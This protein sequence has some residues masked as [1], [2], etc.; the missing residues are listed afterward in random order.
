MPATTRRLNTDSDPGG[1]CVIVKK[2]LVSRGLLRI[3]PERIP[4]HLGSRRVTPRVV[5]VGEREVKKRS[6][7][8][9]AR[10]G[11]P[12]G[13]PAGA[14]I[15]RFGRPPDSVALPIIRMINLGG[16]R[17]PEGVG[18]ISGRFRGLVRRVVRGLVRRVLRA[19]DGTR[20]RRHDEEITTTTTKKRRIVR[21]KTKTN[22]RSNQGRYGTKSFLK[23]SGFGATEF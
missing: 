22:A 16:F 12:R 8:I 4:V 17:S 5:A 11:S 3:S 9:E 15:S 23:T 13:G 1:H 6:S 7:Q 19:S 10:F 2:L 18:A 20:Q 14:R 21:Q